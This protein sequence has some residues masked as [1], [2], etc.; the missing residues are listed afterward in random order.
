[1]F[2]GYKR[3]SLICKSLPDEVKRFCSINT[4]KP[5][6]EKYPTHQ[7]SKAGKIKLT[8]ASR[9]TRVTNLQI[10]EAVRIIDHLLFSWQ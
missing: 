7:V 8:K 3:S 4:F 10:E 1:M 2:F 6:V 5:T 9:I